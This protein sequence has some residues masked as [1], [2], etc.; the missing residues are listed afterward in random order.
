MAYKG[1]QRR[2]EAVELV[3][4]ALD[5][6]PLLTPAWQRPPWASR[7]GDAWERA[8]NGERVR[9]C[10]VVPVRLLADRFVER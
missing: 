5:A 4:G 2:T 9:G 6:V 7:W 10:V 8:V 3:G 1:R